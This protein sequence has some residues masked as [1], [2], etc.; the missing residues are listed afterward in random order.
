MPLVSSEASLQTRAKVWWSGIPLMTR[1]TFAACLALYLV[2][3][4]TGFPD[5]SSICLAAAPVFHGQVYRFLIAALSH[6]GLLHLGMNMLAFLPLGA[7]LERHYGSLQFMWIML[8]LLALGDSLYVLVAAAS[9]ALPLSLPSV[10]DFYRQ[11]AVGLS[12][13]IFG[14]VL[15]DNHH[16]SSPTRSIFGLFSVPT[17]AFPW[18]LLVIWQLLVPRASL[19][20]HLTGLLVGH[21]F[22]TGRLRWLLP[23]SATYQAVERA[24]PFCLHSPSFIA[25]TA[26]S[27]GDAVLPTQHPHG[28]DGNPHSGWLQG[29]WM[30]FP[31]SSARLRMSGLN[32]SSLWG[33]S[34][35][36]LQQQQAPQQQA[37]QAAG[38]SAMGVRL[39]GGQAPSDAKA[40]AAA[41]AEARLAAA[42]GKGSG[43]RGGPG[44]SGGGAGMV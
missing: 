11:C 39:G 31:P 30:P 19:L 14:L 38:P 3:A 4:I 7:S 8:L 25:H 32:L 28:G 18:V 22:V 24:L 41:A 6:A 34:Q 36:D 1:C 12:G 2:P 10:L 15:I 13:V 37:Q 35:P 26:G 17:W 16:A 23:S 40:A 44:G 43:G 5:T 42:G 20:G 9:A 27:G 33:G 21:A 29:P